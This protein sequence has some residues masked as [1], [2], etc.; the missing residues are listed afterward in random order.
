MAATRIYISFDFDNDEDLKNFLVGQAKHSDSPFEVSDW[1][2]K[3]AVTGD[4][5]AMARKRIRAAS[6][7]AVICG[8]HTDVATGVAAE[9]S[10]AQAEGKPYFLLHGRAKG[11][12]KKPRTALKADKVYNWTWDNLKS[13]IAGGR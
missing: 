7:I 4:W 12:V 11:G 2:L 8:H 9:V 1:S 3:E 10:I 5:K 13:L 6:Q